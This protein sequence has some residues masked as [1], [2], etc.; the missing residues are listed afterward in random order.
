MA[1]IFAGFGSLALIRIQ[2]RR[3]TVRDLRRQAQGIVELVDDAPAT[4]AGAPALAVRQ[5]VLQR[6]LRLEGQQIVRFTTSGQA[7]D[8]PPAGVSAADL[9][10]DHLSQGQTVSGVN[11]TLAYA[12]AP[13]TT[14]RRVPFAVVL[15]RH[16]RTGGGAAL[17]L[18]VASGAAP[19]NPNT[20]ASITVRATPGPG[21]EPIPAAAASARPPSTVATARGR[22]IP[23]P[24]GR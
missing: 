13:G 16:V 11:G 7:I 9:R 22:T 4:R 23:A 12:A 19:E 5:R 10:F 1:L 21:T 17:W 2:S 8:N 20:P 24:V 14:A 15:T 6:V 3:D 18:L